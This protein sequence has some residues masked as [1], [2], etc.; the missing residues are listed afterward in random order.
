MDEKSVS[1][2]GGKPP[3]GTRG[4]MTQSRPHASFVTMQYD[5][6]SLF[7]LRRLRKDENVRILRRSEAKTVF[8]SFFDFLRGRKR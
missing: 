6:K 3:A 5:Q 1:V 7:Y 8:G 4:D 2:Q